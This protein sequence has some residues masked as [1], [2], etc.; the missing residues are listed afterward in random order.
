MA[1]YNKVSKSKLLLLEIG[2]NMAKKQ[3]VFVCSSCGNESPKWLG[4]CPFCKEWNT[5]Y[6]ETI[7]KTKN[8]HTVDLP[9]KNQRK[10]PV[11]IEEI[12]MVEEHRV[13][14]GMH[15]LDRVLGGGIVQ[16]SLVLVGG[17]P[18]I[19]KSTLLLQIC[20]N[21][22]IENKKIL[23]ISG[24][25][26]L[27]QIKLRAKRLN[28][29]DENI[30]L[31]TETN[32][33]VIK[34][35]VVKEEPDILMIDSI[36]TMQS[37]QITSLPGS[38]SQ[39]REVTGIL[40]KIAKEL[41]IA[42]FIV[43]H[44]TKDGAIAGPRVLEHMVDTV[45]YFEGDKNASY[46]LLRA[47]KNRFGSTNEMG[48]FRMEQKGLVE[49]MNPSEYM[50]TG[51]P[52]NEPGSLVVCAMEGTRPIFVE[53]QALVAHSSFNMPRRTATGT[54][55]NRV[56]MLLAVLEKKMGVNLYDQDC[57]IN[58]AGGMKMSEPSLDLGIIGA[59]YSGALNRVIDP[60]LVLMGEVGL[61]GEVRGIT[62]IEDRVKEA[63][64]LGFTRCVIPYNNYTDEVKKIDMEII[65]IRHIS[66]MT[67]VI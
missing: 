60:K 22:S 8:K 54:D 17:D 40:M 58:I 30:L 4:Q 11:K 66:Q 52:T 42:T 57:Y 64:K 19:G 63:K 3:T 45:L 28:V 36:Q 6:E 56:I 38:V 14:V 1:W 26:S 37:D 62:Y 41:N 43:G 10:K 21:I 46:R 2:G 33:E 5:F 44:V 67:E 23:Y 55:Y 47:V 13:K 29:H 53:V 50:L 18:G 27:Q 12:D 31:Y 49:V 24:E 34:E 32:M 16:G 9:Q 7:V 51:R 48:I 25:E 39:V 61:T 35:V 20:S 15:E 65:A 59:V